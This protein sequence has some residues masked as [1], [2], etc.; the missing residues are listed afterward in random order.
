MKCKRSECVM[1]R[2]SYQIRQTLLCPIN[3]LRVHVTHVSK[4]FPDLSEMT[5][6]FRNKCCFYTSWAGHIFREHMAFVSGTWVGRGDRR[7]TVAKLECS[8]ERCASVN[9]WGKTQGT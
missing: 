7:H 3:Q 4:L 6:A 2:R 5:R 8:G 9:L 1:K